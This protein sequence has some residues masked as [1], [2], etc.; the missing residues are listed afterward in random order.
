MSTFPKKVQKSAVPGTVVQANHR[1][2]EM[3]LKEDA[4]SLLLYCFYTL[5]TPLL[6]SGLKVCILYYLFF[7]ITFYVKMYW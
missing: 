4:A 7:F 6:L 5:R 1:H 3:S 2:A